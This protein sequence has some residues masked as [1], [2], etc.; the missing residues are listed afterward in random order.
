MKKP[1]GNPQLV[2]MGD[3][4]WPDGRYVMTGTGAKR[5]LVISD[6]LE[7]LQPKPEPWLN[8]DFFSI[9]KPRTIA[10]QLPEA[11][12][13]W[14]LTRA[15]ETNDWQLAGAKVG[16]KLDPSKISSV[17]SPFSSASFND[18]ASPNKRK[19]ANNTVLTVETFDGFNYVANIAPKEDDNYP[20]TFSITANLATER[21]AAKDEKPEDKAKLDKTFKEQQFKLAEK[22]AK[23]K[24]FAN[25]VYQL[26]AFSVDE[27]LKPRQQLLAET[28]TNTPA[29][30]RK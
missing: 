23:E 4:G 2:G 10:V 20:A 22:L 25:W 21:A 19:A 18:V 27:I 28:I 7:N 29:K 6:P 14:K 30:A 1:A 5:L 3:D 9:E 13:S 12:N 17:T 15:S 24:A 16:E 8:K 11:T 26:P